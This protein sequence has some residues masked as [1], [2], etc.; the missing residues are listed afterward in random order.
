M[1]LK[2]CNCSYACWQGFERDVISD[3]TQT[4]AR[5]CGLGVAFE[6]DVISDGTQTV[7]T[8]RISLTEF[9]SDVISDGTQTG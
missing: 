7:I 9:E 2:H 1:V 8:L 3:G 6:R 5:L 4:V